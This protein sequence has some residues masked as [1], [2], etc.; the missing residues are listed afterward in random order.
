MIIN[1]RSLDKIFCNIQLR[2]SRAKNSTRYKQANARAKSLREVALRL[3]D[4][5]PANPA[6]VGCD[7]WPIK[8]QRADFASLL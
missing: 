3:G 2:A 1:R 8:V 7:L 6:Q 4:P 5:N